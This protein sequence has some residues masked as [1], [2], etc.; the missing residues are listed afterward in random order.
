MKIRHLSEEERIAW[1]RLARSENVGPATMEKLMSFYEKPSDALVALPELAARG[2]QM[3]KIKIFPKAQAEK[4]IDALN[5]IGGSFVFSCDEKYSD[6]L[7]TIKNPPA[8]LSVLGKISLLKQKAVAFVGSRNASLN[9]KNLTRQLAFACV[10][11]NINVVSGMALGIDGAAHEGALASHHSEVGTIAVLGCGVDVVY[12]TEHKKMYDQIKEKGLIVSDFPFGTCPNAVHF[13]R[14]NRIIAGL[15]A[16]TIV[17]EAKK[18]SGS[19]ITAHFVQEQQRVLMAVPGSP[20]DDRSIEPNKLIKNGA[21]MVQSAQ[22]IFDAINFEQNDF[23]LSQK[24]EDINIFHL[25]ANDDIDK[26]RPLVLSALS[27]DSVKEEDL[28]AELSLPNSVVSVIL[29]ELELAGRLERHSMGRVSLIGNVK[30]QKTDEEML[31][32]E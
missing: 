6:L 4:E 25:P 17:I 13:P 3:S 14:R 11:N 31:F 15:S 30:A 26:A 23:A 22:D 29:L 21:V 28:C 20:L 18:N 7:G 16:G 32:E 2:G 27:T 9:G 10:E 8:V 19:L 24:Q 1:L 12:P 5:L